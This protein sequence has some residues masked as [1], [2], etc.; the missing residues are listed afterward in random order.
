PAG[1][2]PSP[3]AP[4]SG[5][6]VHPRCPIA[7]PRCALERPELAPVAPG[8]RAACFYPGEVQTP[9]NFSAAGSYMER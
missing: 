2:A 4:P 3:A 1:E 9:E 8:R 6:P 7:R 5:C